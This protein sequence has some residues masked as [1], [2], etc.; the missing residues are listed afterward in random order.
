LDALILF[1]GLNLSYFTGATGMLGG[2]SGSRPFIYLLPR[3]GEPIMIVHQGRQFETRMLTNVKDIRTYSRLSELPLK[4]ILG[5]I[6]ELKL[7]KGRIGAELGMEMVLDLPYAQFGCLIKALPDAAILDASSLLWSLRMI[8]S[9]TEIDCVTKACE[10]TSQA[11]TDTFNAIRP[12]MTECEIESMMVNSMASLGGKAPWTLVT[13]GE[14]NY[15][16]VSKGGG[17]RK[18]QISDMV[19]MDAGCAVN[20]YHSDFS[21]AGVMGGAS[22]LQHDAQ[23]LVHEATMIG[24]ELLRPGVPAAEV[25]LRC[26]AA[27][28][29][30]PFPV[31]SSI[32][33]LAGRVGH[34]LGLFIT[35]LPSLSEHDTTVLAAGMIVTIEPGFATN[36]GTF[37]AEENVLITPEGPRTLSSSHWQ[38]WNI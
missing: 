23:N 9:P 22:R 3:A 27:I 4:E 21:R 14:G 16:L 6:D 18:V 13:S 33:G 37:H 12:G 29:A 32:S 10:I 30:L 34:G 11:Y 7:R 28:E 26:N 31:T 20:G 35:E 15:D 36:Y 8:K 5:A 2:R 24:L 19:W 25:A 17:A 1:T 38:L